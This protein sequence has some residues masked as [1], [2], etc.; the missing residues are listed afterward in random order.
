MD[1][2]SSQLRSI[3]TEPYNLLTCI[4]ALEISST[5]SFD[6]ASFAIFQLAHIPKTES[7]T[8]KIAT[9]MPLPLVLLPGESC[10]ST[11]IKI[12]HRKPHSELIPPQVKQFLRSL[13]V[14]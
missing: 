8:I 3:S 14:N 6:H 13:G 12:A 5:G 2:I 1:L 9:Q 11:P 4:P 10:M 7:A